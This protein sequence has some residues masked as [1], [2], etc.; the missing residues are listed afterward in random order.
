MKTPIA[1][2]LAALAFAAGYFVGQRQGIDQALGDRLGAIETKLADL[3]KA[4]PAA[5]PSEP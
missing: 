3:Q 5:R 2:L 4:Q 1:I